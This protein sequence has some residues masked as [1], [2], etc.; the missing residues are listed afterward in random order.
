MNGALIYLIQIL[1]AFGTIGAF[2]ISFAVL[3]SPHN[4]DTETR[5]GFAILPFALIALSVIS[6]LY[7]KKFR[8]VI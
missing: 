5:L 1:L 2:M 6:F 3:G 7:P 4:V 8:I